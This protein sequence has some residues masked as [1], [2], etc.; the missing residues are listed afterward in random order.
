M[1]PVPFCKS[2]VVNCRCGLPATR[3][4]SNAGLGI[5]RVS[6]GAETGAGAERRGR[7]NMKDYPEIHH[8]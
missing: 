4:D 3:R 5:I 2:D 6:A 1:A 7:R 8:P